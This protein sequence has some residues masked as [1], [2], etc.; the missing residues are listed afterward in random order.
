MY[1]IRM[2]LTFR[3]NNRVH[4][5]VWPLD[6]GE[7]H[8]HVIYEP[9]SIEFKVFIDT[10]KI[11]HVTKNQFSASDEKEIV[12]AVLARKEKIRE[13]WHEFQNDQKK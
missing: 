10:G 13:K 8:V 11:E 5:H 4:I 2:A 1:I 3:F 12:K 6:H 9:H 7:I